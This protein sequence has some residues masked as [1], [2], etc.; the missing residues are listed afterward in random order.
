VI[1]SFI[2]ENFLMTLFLFAGAPATEAMRVLLLAMAIT[3]GD[4][5]SGK[6][7]DDEGRT[8]TLL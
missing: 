4:E 5:N 3:E 8:R 2:R 6:S 7:A 1:I